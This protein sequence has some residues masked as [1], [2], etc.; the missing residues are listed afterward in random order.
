MTGFAFC[1]GAV[2]SSGGDS[3]KLSCGNFLDN[4]TFSTLFGHLK[5]TKKDGGDVLLFRK[6][7]FIITNIQDE[8][9][10]NYPNK[11]KG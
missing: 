7:H 9:F 4:I 3:K 11:K 5:A 1:A 2:G 10:L 8:I 6:D